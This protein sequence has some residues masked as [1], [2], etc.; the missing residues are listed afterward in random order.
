MGG[1]RIGQ[2]GLRPEDFLLHARSVHSCSVIVNNCSFGN[3]VKC[4]Q[5][6][7]GRPL[8]VVVPDANGDGDLDYMEVEALFQKEV[9][10]VKHQ[11][12]HDF[13]TSVVMLL[14]YTRQLT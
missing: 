3:F 10:D 12:T 13:F 8:V 4:I 2:R 1:G 5:L 9:G 14:S 6:L 7:H 11:S